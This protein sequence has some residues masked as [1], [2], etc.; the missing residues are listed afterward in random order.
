MSIPGNQKACWLNAAPPHNYAQGPAGGGA[1]SGHW[2]GLGRREVGQRLGC[3]V[4]E[5]L[6]GGRRA[7]PDEPVP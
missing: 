2:E 3:Q 7:G 4:S 6:R 1:G 5:W